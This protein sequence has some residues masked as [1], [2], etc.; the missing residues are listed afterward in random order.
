M[1]RPTVLYSKVCILLQADNLLGN[2]GEA[3]LRSWTS[4][5]LVSLK[6][7]FSERLRHSCAQHNS[8]AFVSLR[9]PELPKKLAI[10]SAD[11]FIALAGRGFQ[12]P[13]VEHANRPSRIFDDAGLLKGASSFRNAS[14]VCTQ[15]CGEKIVRHWNEARL[16]A[17]LRQQQP[18]CEPLFDCVQPVARGRLRN[19]HTIDN[20]EAAEAHQDIWKST[21]QGLQIAA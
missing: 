10:V 15:H 2:H 20:G 11:Q 1:T 18:T 6:F 14:A 5:G 12:S 16:N 8:G 21:K 19:L 17:I 9:G 13:A 7:R 4:S 3:G